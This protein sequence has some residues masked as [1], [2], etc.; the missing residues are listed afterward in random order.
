MSPYTRSWGLGSGPR[1]Y[2]AED[3]R[4]LSVVRRN[5]HLFVKRREFAW[6]RYDWRSTS[7]PWRR[8]WRSWRS[9]GG[10]GSSSGSGSLRFF[11]HRR[12]RSTSPSG[13]AE[14]PLLSKRAVSSLFSAGVLRDLRKFE[15]TFSKW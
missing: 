1:A 5:F 4:A 13:H 7:P 14:A 10:W 9:G 15:V 6:C 11:E 12:S 3:T 2:S 8:G